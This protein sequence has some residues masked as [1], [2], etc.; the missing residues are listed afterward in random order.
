MNLW[1]GKKKA[2]TFSYDDGVGQ[3]KRLV[4]IFNR[5]D[6]KGT[7][8]IN[9]GIQSAS[10]KWVKGTVEIRRLNV[11]DIKEVYK[12]HEVAA[13]SL[14]H[15]HLELWDEETIENEMDQDMLNIERIFG[16]KPAGMAYPFGTY[17]EKTFKVLKKLGLGYART[18]KSSENFEMQAELLEFSPTCHHNNKKLM[19]LGR[20]FLEL[21]PETPK[22]FYVWGHSFEFDTDDNWALIEEF[23]ALM[24]GKDDIY[25]GTNADVFGL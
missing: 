6:M 24:S 16:H 7:F 22:L 15:P 12:G 17:D 9:T 11:R 14:T 8:N 13:H 1:N 23:C 20:A 25:Y 4:E 21:R 5:Y 10:S 3:D 2:L 19:E 18:V